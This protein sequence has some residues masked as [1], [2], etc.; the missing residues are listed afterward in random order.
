MKILTDIR[1]NGRTV[2]MATHNYSLLQKFP[3]RILKCEEGR[4]VEDKR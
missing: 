1:K 2:I 3:A 4:I